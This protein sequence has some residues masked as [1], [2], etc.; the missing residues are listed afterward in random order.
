MGLL[1]VYGLFLLLLHARAHQKTVTP[2]T[3]WAQPYAFP[4]SIGGSAFS[5][6]Y[7]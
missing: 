3:S 7:A 5:T 1:L 4:G 6:S 2:R